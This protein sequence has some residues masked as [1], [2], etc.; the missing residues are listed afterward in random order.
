MTVNSLI[1]MTLSKIS[2]FDRWK[3]LI[4]ILVDGGAA[5]PA[6]RDTT[7]LTVT[8]LGYVTPMQGFSMYSI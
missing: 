4:W 3:W 7:V 5:D 2:N 1:Q 6:E 8:F